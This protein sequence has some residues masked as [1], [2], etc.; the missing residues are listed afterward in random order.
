[1][2]LV[3]GHLSPWGR[4][5]A[6]VEAIEC[7]SA[8]A[9]V[10]LRPTPII[11]FLPGSDPTWAGAFF[12]IGGGFLGLAALVKAPRRFG[13]FCFLLAATIHAMYAI[14]ALTYSIISHTS[15]VLTS[16][17]FAL[18]ALNVLAAWK[19]AGAGHR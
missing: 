13:I 8:A 12:A 5:W 15:W 6:A 9:S 18:A 3:G 7:I 2:V 17:M 10:Y 4:S 1:V 14:G 19:I 11:N 16:T